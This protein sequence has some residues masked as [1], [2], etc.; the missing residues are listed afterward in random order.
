MTAISVDT[1]LGIE[2][3]LYREAKLLDEE[4]FKEWLDLFAED[5]TYRSHLLEIREVGDERVP[6]PG[7]WGI[8]EDDLF[9]LRK[10]VDRLATG[11]AHAE[12]PRSR[13]RRMITNILVTSADGG[14]VKVESNFIVFQSR[15]GD[16]E[17]FFVGSRQDTLVESGD[18][19]KIAA[20]QI[21]FDQRVLPRAITVFF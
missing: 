11:L 18:D 8:F 1:R 21:I 6:L 3:F 10:R 5:V 4:R 19:W 20:R 7:D 12:K 17:R 16:Y 15:H 14:R 2:A 9:F 13:T